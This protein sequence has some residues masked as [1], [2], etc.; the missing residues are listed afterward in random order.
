[1]ASMVW[2]N[3]MFVVNG[4]D[5]SDHIT[6]L[7]LNYSS[8]MLDRTVMGL[9]TRAKVGG[10]K[11]WSLDVTFL[12]NFAAA[13]SDATLFPLV[14]TTSCVEVRPLNSCSTQINPIYTG[15]A[16]LEAYPPMGGAVGTLLVSKG[17]F[18]AAGDLSRA[19]SS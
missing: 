19:S 18:Q 3:A 7:T 8:E 10:L 4:V 17:T 12:Q 5:L 6:E 1:M 2:K 14:G 15:V 11:N 13:K 9:T 16:T